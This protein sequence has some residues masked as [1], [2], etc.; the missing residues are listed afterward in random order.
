MKTGIHKMLTTAAMIVV[1]LNAVAKSDQINN[2]TND[3]QMKQIYQP[4]QHLLQREK[5]GFVNIYDGFT[6]TQ[7][8]Q[9][10]DQKFSRLENMMFTRVK[11]TDSQGEVLKDPESGEDIVADDGCD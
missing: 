11:Q 10:M 3:W 4:S 5:R 7:V 2:K 9:V 1:S 8:E 6:D